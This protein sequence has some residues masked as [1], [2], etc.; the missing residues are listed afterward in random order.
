MVSIILASFHFSSALT[1]H[2]ACCQRVVSVLSA[3][4]QRVVTVLSAVRHPPR[5][6]PAGLHQVRS[7]GAAAVSVLSAC[8]QRVVSVLSPCCH[9]VVSGTSPPEASTSWPTSS[10]EWG[11]CCCQRVV[12]VLS[13]CCQRVVTV[14]SPCCQ[15]YV[16]PRGI[17]QLAYI[18]YG[19]GGLLL[20]MLIF[21]VWMPL[22]LFSIAQNI[23]IVNVP[24][25]CQLSVQ[26]NGYRVTPPPPG[27]PF[28]P[29]TPV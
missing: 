6:Q 8:C 1:C 18:K 19:V 20:L 10:T 13:A 22:I 2:P 15:R 26:L 21:V 17:N 27:T 5:H 24:V 16:T 25:E 12:S 4:C 28:Q 3:C 11:G 23:Y 9:R 14:L 29:P 7:G